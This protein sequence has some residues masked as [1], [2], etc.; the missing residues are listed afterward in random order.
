MLLQTAI[1]TGMFLLRLGV[2][3]VITLVV[4]YGLRRLDAR[5]QAEALLEWEQTQV[6]QK[7]AAAGLME[8]LNQPCWE[9]KGCSEETRANCPACEDSNIPCWMAWRQPD[10]RL[11]VR[12]Y[13]CERLIYEQMGPSLEVE[14]SIQTYA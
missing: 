14:G 5:W 13:E 6:Q 7:F 12:C 2:P 3:I 8:R 10:G 1:I 11:P 4:A 9:V